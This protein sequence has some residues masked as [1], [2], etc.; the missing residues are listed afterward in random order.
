MLFKYRASSSAIILALIFILVFLALP[1]SCQAIYLNEAY[2]A[3]FVNKSHELFKDSNLISQRSSFKL[4]CTLPIRRL[5]SLLSDDTANFHIRWFKLDSVLNIQKEFQNAEE[6]NLESLID[7]DND[8]DFSYSDSIFV[9]NV[10][11]NISSSNTKASS[12]LIFKFKNSEDLSR[13]GGFYL[14]RL[15][16]RNQTAGSVKKFEDSQYI[17]QIIINGKLVNLSGYYIFLDLLLISRFF[18]EIHEEQTTL[19]TEFKLTY[20]VVQASN[21]RIV[22][23]LFSVLPSTSLSE[24]INNTS[25]LIYSL[26]K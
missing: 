24:E 6:P 16:N 14:C 12:S 1:S 19:N 7:E 22:L 4:K 15:D 8:D 17:Q 20:K 26:I 2:L 13:A 25:R 11:S 10:E 9:S 3:K 23:E 21:F 18:E 5:D